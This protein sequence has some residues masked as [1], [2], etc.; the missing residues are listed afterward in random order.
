MGDGAIGGL[1]SCALLCSQASK[2]AK[3]PRAA[4]LAAQGWPLS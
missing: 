2:A 3:K 1:V 4:M